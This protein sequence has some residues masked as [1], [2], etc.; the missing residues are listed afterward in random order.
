MKFV[1]PASLCALSVYPMISYAKTEPI[2][3]YAGQCS[4]ESRITL[5]GK[6]INVNCKSVSITVQNDHMVL[7]YHGL[8]ESIGFT[9]KRLT[10]TNLLGQPLPIAPVEQV[11]INHS[12]MAVDKGQCVFDA[13]ADTCTYGT[14]LIQPL[15]SSCSATTKGKPPLNVSIFFHTE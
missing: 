1:L 2:A 3:H 11:L 4:P 10:A 15:A 12:A 9:F 7:F 14:C 6:T 8:N 5:D 13:K